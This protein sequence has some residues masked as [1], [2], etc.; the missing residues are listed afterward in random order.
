MHIAKFLVPEGIIRTYLCW[1]KHIF[2]LKLDFLEQMPDSGEFISLKWS[3]YRF[4]SAQ[5]GYSVTIGDFEIILELFSHIFK[6]RCG[7]AKCSSVVNGICKNYFNQVPHIGPS[8]SSLS[9]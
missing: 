2:Q 7:L 9:S 6:E 5:S 1:S 4:K 8:K 3:R